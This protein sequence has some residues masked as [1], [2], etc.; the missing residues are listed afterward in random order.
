MHYPHLLSLAWW[1]YARDIPS[2]PPICSHLISSST[3]HPLLP[4]IL[5]PPFTS[6]LADVFLS[7]PTTNATWLLIATNSP[8][9][10]QAV[11]SISIRPFLVCLRST[12]M[13]SH[14]TPWA[15]RVFLKSMLRRR[16]GNQYLA[17]GLVC[18]VG[19]GVWDGA[20]VEAERKL[21]GSGNMSQA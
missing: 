3:P 10:S 13:N 18:W 9:S 17:P 4:Q 11:I 20:G 5:L 21:E 7:L 2:T 14:S 19:V 8:S 16:V 6:L 12:R 15:G 1:L